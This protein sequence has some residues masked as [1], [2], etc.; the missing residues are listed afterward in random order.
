[1]SEPTGGK[2][3][4]MP[5]HTK[6]LLGLVIGAVLGILANTQLGGEHP[7]VLFVEK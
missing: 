7:A 1:M 3:K 5:L 6:I 2:S 4:G